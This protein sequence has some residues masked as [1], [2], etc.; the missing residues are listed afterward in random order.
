MQHKKIKIWQENYN[1][2]ISGKAELTTYIHDNSA[3]INPERKRPALLICPGGGYS[4]VSDREGEPVAIR[5]L[6]AGFNVFVLKYEVAPAVTHPQPLFDVSRAMW[7]IR[8]NAQSWNVDPD[9]IAVCGFSA[10]GH[11][12]ASLGVF[13]HKDYISVET[14]MPAGIN[15]PNALILGYPVI[16]SGIHAHMPSL[17]NLLGKDCEND[18]LE[19]MSLEKQVGINT[20]PAFVWHTFDDPHVPVENAL[21]FSSALRQN[22]IPFELHIF[23]KGGHG[24]SLANEET[25][26]ASNPN[27][28]DSHVANWVVLCEQWLKRLWNI[29]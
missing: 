16:T 6:Q 17:N 8:E 27:Q 26:S 29:E 22:G 25:T 20:P 21:L 5:F 23:D 2:K 10:G 28:I 14:S 9:K 12:C 18:L 7:I 24:L 19:M 13:W 4:K 1:G 11:L 3:Q 15:K